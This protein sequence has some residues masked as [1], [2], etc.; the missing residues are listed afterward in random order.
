MNKLSYLDK[1]NI[2]RRKLRWN[3]QYKKGRWDYLKD[4]KEAPRYAKIIELI[5]YHSKKKPSILDLGSGEGVL[6]IRLDTENIG[7][8]LGIDFSKFSIETA[9]KYNFKNTDFH[10][11]DLHYYKP[12]Q[13][14]DVIIF[15]E[16]FYYIN[17]T[18][19][20]RVLNRVLGKLKKGGIL[21]NSIFREGSG[22]WE[23]FDIPELEQL[24]F[25][26]VN[27]NEGTVYWKLGVYRKN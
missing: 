8:F 22:C 13:E 7:Y 3:R 9:N 14:F 24:D 18:V 23:Y 12:P 21:I 15:N 26:K 16:A 10:V 27:S 6:R 20:A 5:K 19:K 11:G 4:D 2:W 25:C 1:F 17:D